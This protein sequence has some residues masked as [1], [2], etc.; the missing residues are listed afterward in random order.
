[1]AKDYYKH[2]YKQ[3]VYSSSSGRPH[4]LSIE[5]EQ[6]FPD[7]VVIYDIWL[8]HSVGCQRVIKPTEDM[9]LF[10]TTHLF[11]D[12]LNKAA[13]IIQAQLKGIVTRETYFKTV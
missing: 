3:I 2:L 11:K 7:D 9:L 6:T 4:T 12:D 1:M 10:V 8:V 5:Y 13:K